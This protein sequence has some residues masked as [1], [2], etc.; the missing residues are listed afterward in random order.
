[1]KEAVLDCWAEALLPQEAGRF[2]LPQA[3]GQS[4]GKPVSVVVSLFPRPGGYVC[5]HFDTFRG[6]CHVWEQVQQR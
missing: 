4:Q 3:E 1:M 5:L 2:V 6:I